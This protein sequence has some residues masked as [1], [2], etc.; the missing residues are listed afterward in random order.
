MAYSPSRRDFLRLGIG[1]AAL[2]SSPIRAYLFDDETAA[3][4]WY[5]EFPE[6]IPG[7][8]EARKAIRAPQARYVLAHLRQ[9]HHIDGISEQDMQEVTKVQNDLYQSL[10]FLV[11]TGRVK[12]IYNEAVDPDKELDLR[13][14]K[15]AKAFDRLLDYSMAAEPEEG[16]SFTKTSMQRIK[17]LT[18]VLNNPSTPEQSKA[19]IRKVI[20]AME[21]SMKKHE[22]LT[23][24]RQENKKIL[25]EHKEQSD[26]SRQQ[27]E[28][29]IT[30][31]ADAAA[32]LYV[33]GRLDIVAAETYEANAKAGIKFYEYILETVK[34]GKALP[35][36][37]EVTEDRE[38]ILLDF[39]SRQED[40]VA[41]TKY[42]GFHDWSD[43]IPKWNEAHPDKKF[44]LIVVTPQSYVERN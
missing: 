7:A 31:Y 25:L 36:P 12:K 6:K 35:M 21:D 39:V 5:D 26:A 24:Q 2:L 33:E 28:D 40:P 44:S 37:K 16:D 4:K 14:F 8:R 9:K 18:K 30:K 17:D 27:F 42:G 11:K 41:V 34:K 15:Q 22:E 13:L 19:G 43:N 32:R 29:D 1:S 23:R 20:S 38:D 3:N 10:D